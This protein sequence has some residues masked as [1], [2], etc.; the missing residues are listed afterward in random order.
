[1]VSFSSFHLHCFEAFVCGRLRTYLF[2][3]QL[4]SCIGV[5]CMAS[6]IKVYD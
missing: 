6:L 1:M 4:A 2:V 5:R 3:L